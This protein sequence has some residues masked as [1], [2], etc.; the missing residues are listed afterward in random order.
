MGVV[1]RKL[2]QLV[3]AKFG[4]V[5]RRMSGDAAGHKPTCIAATHASED[6]WFLKDLWI[7]LIH[8]SVSRNLASKDVKELVR[9]ARCQMSCCSSRSIRNVST[10]QKTPYVLHRGIHGSRTFCGEPS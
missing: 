2:R 8:E 3:G 9:S 5:W 10:L 7:Y 1:A 4:V 6:P